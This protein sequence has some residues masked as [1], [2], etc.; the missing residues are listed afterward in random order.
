MYGNNR[1]GVAVHV[2]ALARVA[3]EEEAGVGITSERMAESVRAHPVHVRRVLGALREAGLV[4]SQPGPGGGWKLTRSPEAI[5]LRDIYRAVEHEPLF[6]VPQHP[7]E[8]CPISQCIPGV[9]ATCFREAEAALEERLG[10]VTIADVI[11]AVRS[12][13]DRAGFSPQ[14]AR[15]ASQV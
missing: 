6:G 3:M 10:Q 9:L 2:L 5:T 4:T 11:D 1:F 15:L 12:A 7:S 14:E 13:V 8:D